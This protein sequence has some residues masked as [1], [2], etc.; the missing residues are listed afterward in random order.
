MFDSVPIHEWMIMSGL[1]NRPVM[2]LFEGLCERL[3]GT[4]LA[5]ERAHLSVALLHP[6]L[7]GFSHT[8][9]RG[10]GALDSLVFTHG[11]DETQG[12]KESPFKFMLEERQTVLR[13]R[14][15]GN[16][17]QLD[18][19]VLTEFRDEGLTDWVAFLHSFSPESD[20]HWSKL[21]GMITSWATARPGGF[22]EDDAVLLQ[23]LIGT[24]AVVVKADTTQ[25]I[26]RNLLNTYVGGNSVERVL[27][28]EITRGDVQRIEAAIL[29]ADLRGFTGFSDATPIEGTLTFL[30]AAF[31]AMGGPV[32]REGGHILKF[33][34][35][36]LMAIFPTDTDAG[37][38]CRRA[39]AAAEAGQ[40]AMTALN[41]ARAAEGLPVLGLD[42]AL[43]HGEVL[44]GNV[45]TAERL[46]FTI[47]GPAVNEASRIETL[48]KRLERPVLLSE[49]FATAL[50]DH[51]RLR[52]LGT[53]ELAG[54]A[55]PRRI[56]GIG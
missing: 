6:S 41:E 38:A 48:C 7:R 51:P 46:D 19:P 2:G 49:S 34:G 22:A 50:G 43:H 12:W 8:W 20:L 13:R 21:T 55:T 15:A 56:F 10:S 5:I 24:C 31:D 3:A 11:M 23:E 45:G 52:E 25:Q 30:N 17:A 16:R 32:T 37:E 33:L 26:M 39:L 14:L 40:E 47:V 1:E 18:F 54:L 35:D 28:G 42:L 4:P 29:F 44:Y 27:A 53:H 36:G 9:H